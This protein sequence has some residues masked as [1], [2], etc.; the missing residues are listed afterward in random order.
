MVLICSTRP[1]LEAQIPQRHGLQGNPLLPV[2]HQ[3]MTDP[4]TSN[5]LAHCPIATSAG[6]ECTATA[7]LLDWRHFVE[8]EGLEVYLN[9]GFGVVD[10]LMRL[11]LVAV[12]I[13]RLILK[14]HIYLF[15]IKKN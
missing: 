11:L 9:V 2:G 13:V 7:F 14:V 15:R 3:R 10:G 1:L 12:Q 4:P 5:Q 8:R 6:S